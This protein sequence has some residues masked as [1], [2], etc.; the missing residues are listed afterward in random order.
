M[1]GL[2][3]FIR[4]LTS[5]PRT[6]R[7]EERLRAEIEEHIGMQIADNLRAGM[8]PAEA[9]RQA[10]L[11][12]G[13]VEAIKEE[14]REQR[15]LPFLETLAQD[16]RYAVRRLRGAPA[17]TLT[18]VLTLALGIGAT[19]SIFTLVYAVLMK[20]LAVA[21]PSELY[22]L[23][24]EVHCC[25][26]GGYTQ[27]PE[28]SLVSDE[29]YLCLRDHT[30]GFAEL[31]AFS[32]NGGPLV[33]VRRAGS[34]EAA[35][36]YRGEFVSGNYFLMFGV[37]A[38]AGRM[39]TAADDADG[40]HP[41]AIMSHR[42]W[43]E[44]YN[45]DPSVI[46]SVF[47]F[48][49]T[50]LTVVGIAPASFFGDTLLEMPPDFFLPLATE[51]LINKETALLRGARAHWLDLI[52]RIQPGASP[53]SI[54]AQ[55][56]VGLKQWL[57]SH[58]G[59]MDANERVNFPRQTL[60]LSP[61]GA[62]ITV[63]RGQYEHSL[64]ILMLVS[65]FVLAIVC[66]NVASLTLVRGMES[67][68]RT[69]LSMALGARASRVVRQALTESVLLSLLGGVAGLAAAFAGTRLI[70]H[71]AFT[72]VPG[73]A[74]VPIS[75]APSLPVLAF[76]FSVSLLTGIAFGVAPAWMAAR[77][78]PIEALR[79]SHRVTGRSASLPRQIL[80]VVQAALS[81]VLLSA[82]GLLTASLH[83]LEYQDF[84]FA[85]EGRTIVNIDPQLAGYT[86]AQ[87]TPLYQRI[88]DR[89]AAIPGVESVA[90]CGY[91]PQ[92]GGSW[93]DGV[94]VDGHP[95]PGP[96]EDISS[97]FDRVTAGYFEAI[98]QP[99]LR[100]R[101]ITEADT[102]NSPHVAVI[103]DAFARKFFGSEDP[104]GRHFG[105]SEYAASR[106]Y[107][108]VGIAKD[109]RYLNYDL[110]KPIGP[111][112][113]L[114]EAQHDVFSRPEFTA[115]DLRTHYF[116]DIVVAMKPGA[117]LSD[118]A[119]RQALGSVDPNLPAIRTRSLSEQVSGQFSQQRLIARLTSFFGILSLVLAAMG[120]YGVTAYNAGRRTGEI[121]LRMALG[122]ARGQ[123]VA[124]VLRSGLGLIGLGLIFGLPAAIESGRFLGDQLYGMSPHN[125]GATVAAV[126][127]LAF[128]ALV[129]CLIPAL[130]ASRISP[131]D[132]LR[133][134]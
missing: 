81:L 97:V 105:R 133:A 21:N 25:V 11:R 5:W 84:G 90:L 113:I 23:G 91:S 83:R 38:F 17:F 19:T 60:Y 3:R 93:I 115:G 36:G 31:A 121:G 26:F 42:L 14:Y 118:G 13:G 50:P 15:T 44:K 40:A 75:A 64:Q 123:V 16:T 9:R 110:D 8:S 95:A 52:G 88:H 2:K 100:G 103:N 57:Q 80:V 47:N 62:G 119:V 69:S 98:G 106:Q 102:A 99:I 131:I 122:A 114:P 72:P 46:G 59:D 101:G 82:S 65:A 56:R 124:L 41:V 20:S 66:A 107:E 77:V 32:A 6:A 134:E 63:M 22:R 76:A 92:R 24:R 10:M 129:A 35:Q 61:G 53:A 74:H 109:A 85:Q 43:R 39:L 49:N 96:N 117:T 1:R 54:E 33:G 116:G 28:F 4:R 104:I 78:D 120:L 132:A 27:N 108:I 125:I 89:L 7:D 67:R 45:A 79:G 55:M 94:F 12:F 30:K 34:Q 111:F 37:N 112:F 58:W 68:R 130:R 126:A 87:L 127:A 86:A 18:T 73:F 71:F 48:D 128:S 70:L 29:L 51:P